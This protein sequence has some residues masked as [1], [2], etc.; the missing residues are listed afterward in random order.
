MGRNFIWNPTRIYP[1]SFKIFLEDLTLFIKNKY[2]ASYADDTTPYETGG[3]SAYVIHNLKVL[4][5]TLFN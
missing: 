2:V 4:G 5:N 3:N 1:R